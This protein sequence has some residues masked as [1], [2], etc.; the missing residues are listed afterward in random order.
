MNL[1]NVPMNGKDLLDSYDRC[2]DIFSL[3]IIVFFVIFE[4]FGADG[5]Q[6]TVF[7][8]V[9]WDSPEITPSSFTVEMHSLDY[10]PHSVLTFLEQISHGLWDNTY[11]ITNAPHILLISTVQDIDQ[12]PYNFSHI[13][14]FEAV[15][16]DHL[17]FQEYHEQYPHKPMTLGF[18]GRPAGPNFYIN[19]IDNTFIHGPGGQA[20][21]EIDEEADPC[22]ATVVAGKEILTRIFALP[23]Q[24]GSSYELFHPVKIVR[25]VVHRKTLTDNQFHDNTISQRNSNGQEQRKDV[26][27]HQH[28]EEMGV[29][30]GPDHESALN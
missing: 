11:F 26:D 17:L 28:N 2:N 16:L 19:K 15:G 1:D 27:E 7:L 4:R 21:H 12:K 30:H 13:S 5:I 20:H 9:P 25:A 10:M 3:I 8:D 29:E 24:Q 23:V 14:D 18:A 22:F 6:V